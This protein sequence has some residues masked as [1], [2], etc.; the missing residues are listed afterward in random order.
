[1]SLTVLVK[2]YP[3]LP[4]F[5]PLFYQSLLDD[6]TL[7]PMA[8]PKIGTIPNSVIGVPKCDLLRDFWHRGKRKL[9]QLDAFTAHCNPRNESTGNHEAWADLSESYRIAIRDVRRKIVERTE[10]YKYTRRDILTK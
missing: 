8:A 3:L 7:H 5:Y 1:M 4:E 9:Q 6:L 2:R 10:N